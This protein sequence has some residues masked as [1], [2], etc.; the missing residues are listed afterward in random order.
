MSELPDDLERALRD[1]DAMAARRAE[2]VDAERVAAR[3]TARLRS[4]PV[5]GARVV[6]RTWA[7]PLSP[8][9]VGLAAAAVVVVLA[10]TMARSILQ[11]GGAARVPV[12]V[13]AQGLDSLDVQGLERLLQVAGEVRPST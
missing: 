13:I 4:E 12:P 8:R 5:R 9:W 10:G 7:L 2:R 3:V 6:A 11:P 1:L